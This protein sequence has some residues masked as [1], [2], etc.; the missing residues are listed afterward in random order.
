MA[1]KVADAAKASKAYEKMGY[2]PTSQA[3]TPI[4]R[5]ED[6][7]YQDTWGKKSLEEYYEEQKKLYPGFDVTKMP[8]LYNQYLS[9]M[10]REKGLM[11]A[12]GGSGGTVRAPIR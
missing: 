4:G 9:E 5:W 8:R 7:T 3:L 12:I 2:T 1:A 11:G 6:R 10:E